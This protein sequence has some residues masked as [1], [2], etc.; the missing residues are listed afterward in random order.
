MAGTIRGKNRKQRHARGDGRGREYNADSLITL[1]DTSS[2]LLR[3]KKKNGKEDGNPNPAPRWNS[4]SRCW[5]LLA[6]KRNRIGER[7]S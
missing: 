5:E 1:D 2:K 7:Y 4:Q 3:K 6:K